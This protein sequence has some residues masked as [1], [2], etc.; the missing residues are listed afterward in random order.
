M[1]ASYVIHAI[2]YS[3]GSHTTILFKIDFASIDVL[4]SCFYPVLMIQIGSC[5]EKIL[6]FVCWDVLQK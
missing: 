3:Y 2:H 5:V 6:K 1:F 4:R